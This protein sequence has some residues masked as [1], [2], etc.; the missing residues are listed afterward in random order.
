[1]ARL[2][3]FT[4][5]FDSGRARWTLTNDRTRRVVKAF[6]S[7]QDATRGGVLRTALPGR[8]ASVRIHKTIGGFQQERTYPRSMDP[9]RP[10][11]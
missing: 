9:A 7:K 3:R 6:G 1:M 5:A 10:R 8:S 2:H 4:F 11:G